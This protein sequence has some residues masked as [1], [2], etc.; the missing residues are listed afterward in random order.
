MAG[1][2]VAEETPAQDM[3]LLAR[4]PEPIVAA[5]DEECTPTPE[6]VEQFAKAVGQPIHVESAHGGAGVEALE[7][8]VGGYLV[9]PVAEELS[10][11]Q[12]GS[13]S[14]ELEPGAVL[15][16]RGRRF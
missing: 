4:L 13:L 14:R 2:G 1:Y 11:H 12:V 15:G 3:E 9:L 10:N 8:Q 7:V 16:V 5:L 6:Q